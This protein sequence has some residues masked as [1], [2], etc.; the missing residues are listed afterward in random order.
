[1]FSRDELTTYDVVISCTTS[2][3]TQAGTDGSRRCRLRGNRRC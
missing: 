1:M 2:D 3:L